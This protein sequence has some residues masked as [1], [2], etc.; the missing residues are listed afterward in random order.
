MPRTARGDAVRSAF[1]I[2]GKVAAYLVMGTFALMTVA[3][4]LWLVMNSLKSTP[5]YRLNKLSLPTE[6]AW[7][8][9]PGA[10]EIGEFSKLI[11]NSF[12]YT[13]G[14]HARHRG[15]APSWRRSPSPRSARGPRRSSTAASSWGSCSPSSR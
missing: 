1:G 15:A 6:L 8:N 7:V 9:Y 4:I 5:E 13:A 12:I 11:G 14:S 2:A 10:W 3:P